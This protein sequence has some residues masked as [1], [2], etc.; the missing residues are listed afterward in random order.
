MDIAA[1][2][3]GHSVR[4]DQDATALQAARAGSQ[5]SQGRWMQVMRRF[6]TRAHVGR[7]VFVHLAPIEVGNA[8]RIDVNSS[9]LQK[10]SKHVKRSNGAL[11]ERSRQEQ[12][13]STHCQPD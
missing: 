3:V 8:T 12:K 1:F 9:T 10:E 2:K 4:S 13:A 7:N 5:A 11:E 6:I